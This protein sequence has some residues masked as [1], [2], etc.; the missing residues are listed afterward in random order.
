MCRA[1]AKKPSKKQ[2]KSWVGLSPFLQ[3][4]GAKMKKKR[5]RPGL[6]QPLIN[7]QAFNQ[8]PR[9]LLPQQGVNHL[10]FFSLFFTDFLYSDRYFVLW[11]LHFWFCFSMVYLVCS[12]VLCIV[13]YRLLSLD[14]SWDSSS[15]TWPGYFTD[16]EMNFHQEAYKVNY[17]F[18][19]RR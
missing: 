5:R 18:P 19:L 15:I 7:S 17:L 3:C 14:V 13:V 4:L 12:S 11:F 2:L 16:G 10:I 6:Y 1:K 9:E 8:N